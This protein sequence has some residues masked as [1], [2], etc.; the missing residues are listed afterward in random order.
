MVIF[1]DHLI[2][3]LALEKEI[4][5]FIIGPTYFHPEPAGKYLTSSG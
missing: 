5:G 1:L 4:L 2:N 3:K